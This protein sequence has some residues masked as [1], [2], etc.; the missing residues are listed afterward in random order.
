M[1]IHAAITATQT[2]PARTEILRCCMARTSSVWKKL[3]VERWMEELQRWLKNRS[4]LRAL[5]QRS[6]LWKCRPPHPAVQLLQRRLVGI[7]PPG[8]DDLAAAGA[9]A[10]LIGALVLGCLCRRFAS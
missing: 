8:F 4:T 9:A 2:R 3:P 10:A 1:Y 6:R 7:L 5:Q